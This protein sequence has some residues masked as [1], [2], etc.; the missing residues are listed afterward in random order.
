MEQSTETT[1][2]DASESIEQLDALIAATQAKREK[3]VAAQRAAAVAEMKAKMKKLGITPEMLRRDGRGGIKGTKLAIKYASG[4]N[5]WSG[6]G[7]TPRWVK[8]HLEA[9]GTMEELRIQKGASA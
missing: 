2:A 8:A 3:L 5:K 6:N 7:I 9:G 1:V 4:D